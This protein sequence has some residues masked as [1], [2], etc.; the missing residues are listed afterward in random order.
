[1]RN[2]FEKVLKKIKEKQFLRNTVVAI[3]C[4]A[5]VACSLGVA[6]LTVSLSV[7]S[8]VSDKIISEDEAAVLED[9][10]CILVLGAGLRSDGSPSDMLSDRLNVGIALMNKGFCD[11]L[12]LSGDNSGEHYNE[13][14]AMLDFSIANGIDESKIITDDKG[15]STYESIFNALKN[16]GVEKIVIV[17]QEYHLY[18]ALYIAKALGIEAYG[19]H[20]DLRTY[21]GQVYRDVREH[22]ARFKDF[23]LTI[24]KD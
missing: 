9:V 6:V 16:H 11:K 10:D 7:K 22:F 19:V 4:I 3:L 20:A 12:L 24:E 1:M 14:G 21:R 18:R 15:Y 5:I 8:S 17:T 23:I 2:F 13:V